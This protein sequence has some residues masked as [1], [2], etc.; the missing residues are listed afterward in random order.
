MHVQQSWRLLQGYCSIHLFY[1]SIYFFI[2]GL[3]SCAIKWNKCCSKTS[4]FQII[5]KMRPNACCQLKNICKLRLILTFGV[6]QRDC[7]FTKSPADGGGAL[8][9]I[10]CIWC[11]FIFFCCIDCNIKLTG[12]A[13][14][15]VILCN[16]QQ[17]GVTIDGQW[18]ADKQPHR[19]Y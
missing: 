13:L 18:K 3:V 11:I 17:R 14:V 19:V 1:H 5:Y 15:G 6:I 2:A 7:L 12:R 4:V 9:S 8:S 16:R 10:W